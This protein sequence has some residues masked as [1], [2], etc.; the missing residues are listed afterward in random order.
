MDSGCDV[1][2][3]PGQMLH[4]DANPTVFSV[5]CQIL[6]VDG[7]S[8]V[9]KMEIDQNT[10]FEI[11]RQRKWR[12]Q[13]NIQDAVPNSL[14]NSEAAWIVSSVMEDRPMQHARL[15][16]TVLSCGA[17]IVG[18]FSQTYRRNHYYSSDAVL[19][20]SSDQRAALI[21]GLRHLAQCSEVIQLDMIEVETH[22]VNAWLG[23]LAHLSVPMPGRRELLCY[24]THAD[25]P[26]VLLQL[27]E[28]LGEQGL[29]LRYRKCHYQSAPHT[30]TPIFE[31]SLVASMPTRFNPLLMNVET[32]ED[33]GFDLELHWPMG[34]SGVPE[35]ESRNAHFP[36]TIGP[37]F[38]RNIPVLRCLWKN[39]ILSNPGRLLRLA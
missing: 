11:G 30:G 21:D 26:G 22:R 28:H 5:L 29:N 38:R 14:Q 6:N 32:L 36:H 33:F 9:Q 15:A 24:A 7:I 2:V 18:S 37:S 34:T 20:S 27:E 13:M 35:E 25:E 1:S 19:A 10:R 12:K 31:C 16:K 8:R 3:I 17:S 23:H 4:P 39:T